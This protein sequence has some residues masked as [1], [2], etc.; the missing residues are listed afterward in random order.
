MR[1]SAGFS[2]V[3]VLIS[4][5]ILSVAL[6]GTAALT[7]ASLKNTNNSYYRSLATIFADDMLDRMRANVVQA[8]DGKYNFTDAGTITAGSSLEHFDCVEWLNAVQDALPG[9]TGTVDVDTA[10]DTVTIVITWGDDG[11]NSFT[12]TSL[13]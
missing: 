2:L 8:R 9:G 6:L 11:A 4:I 3:E 10:A 12:T 7:A 5:A 13:L 1:R